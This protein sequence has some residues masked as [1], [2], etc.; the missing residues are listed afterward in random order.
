MSIAK[1][2][3]KW[4]RKHMNLPFDENPYWERA[5]QIV[6]DEVM[7]EAREIFKLETG[8]T[9]SNFALERLLRTHTA[10]MLIAQEDRE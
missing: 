2:N 8:K 4:Q 1:T 3:D 7:A 10:N 9:V 6:D 5:K